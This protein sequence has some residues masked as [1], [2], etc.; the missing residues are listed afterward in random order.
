M[1]IKEKELIFRKEVGLSFYHTHGRTH[2]HSHVWK[3]RRCAIG[4][5]DLPMF[6]NEVDPKVD[7]SL[8]EVSK[9]VRNL[10]EVEKC[11]VRR[12]LG[13]PIIIE[14]IMI[15]RMKILR[16]KNSSLIQVKHQLLNSMTF[17]CFDLTKTSRN[18]KFLS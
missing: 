9:H 8:G 11:A 2:R 6:R 12:V 13:K 4:K 5:L 14:N 17:S 7:Q 18:L 10:H 16:E 15:I 3:Q 1:I